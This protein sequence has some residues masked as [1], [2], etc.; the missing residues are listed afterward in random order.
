MKR[1]NISFSSLAYDVN[2]NVHVPC[3]SHYRHPVSFPSQVN[4][5][6]NLIHT[7][8][9][10]TVITEFEPSFSFTIKQRLYHKMRSVAYSG[11]TQVLISVQVA[12]QLSRCVSML[13][14]DGLRVT[15]RVDEH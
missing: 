9:K 2:T 13:T 6:G 8:C 4:I 5:V 15:S 14:D 10:Y 7:A 1:H 11:P 3:S 12:Y